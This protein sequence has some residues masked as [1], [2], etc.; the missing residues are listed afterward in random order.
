MRG[1][2]DWKY[3]PLLHSI[4]LRDAV[5]QYADNAPPDTAAVDVF[6]LWEFMLHGK[7]FHDLTGNG[8][9]HPNDFGHRIYAAA[10]LNFLAPE[11]FPL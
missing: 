8:V 1:N 9:N 2:P 4:L 5:R 3:T 6:Q 10:L 7:R 11:A